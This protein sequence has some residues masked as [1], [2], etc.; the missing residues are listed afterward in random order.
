MLVI[1]TNADK[2][3]AGMWVSSDGGETMTQRIEPVVEGSG[4]VER[5]FWVGRGTLQLILLGTSGV[6]GF[7]PDAGVTLDNKMGN[8]GD[9]TSIGEIVGYVEKYP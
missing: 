2:S 7:S 1:G 6:I 8:I 5:A 4:R 3:L 9:L